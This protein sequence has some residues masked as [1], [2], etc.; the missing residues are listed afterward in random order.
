MQ[1]NS[2]NNQ[3]L[4]TVSE[5]ARELEVS[6]ATVRNYEARGIL[7]G[8]RL[9]NGTRVFRREDVEELKAKRERS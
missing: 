3:D 2:Q 8:F 6:E 9:S 5:I 1:D 4:V 7:K